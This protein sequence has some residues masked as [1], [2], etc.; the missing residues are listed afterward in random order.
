MRFA[1][2]AATVAVEAFVARAAR[3][4][5]VA[6]RTAES[7]PGGDPYHRLHAAHY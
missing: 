5:A 2:R 6:A 7:L 4:S 3:S 1:L